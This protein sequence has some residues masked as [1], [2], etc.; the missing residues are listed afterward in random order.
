MNAMLNTYTCDCNGDKNLA[1][2]CALVMNIVLKKQSAP[3]SQCM[4]M[5]S[6]G[7]LKRSSFGYTMKCSVNEHNLQVVREAALPHN[8]NGDNQ[9]SSST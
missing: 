4:Y 7:N 9:V 5:L 3:R 8:D 2:F 6:G 1:S